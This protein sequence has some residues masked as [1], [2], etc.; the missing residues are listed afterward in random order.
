MTRASYTRKQPGRI[1]ENTNSA[2]RKT[3][4]PAIARIFAPA[5]PLCNAQDLDWFGKPLP[6]LAKF[7][8]AGDLGTTTVAPRRRSALLFVRRITI[9]PDNPGIDQRVRPMIEAGAFAWPY[10]GSISDLLSK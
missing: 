1:S 9:V 6:E 10:R 4:Y 8:A 5:L 2:S 3:P 7:S